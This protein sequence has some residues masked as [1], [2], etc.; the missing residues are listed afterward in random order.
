MSDNATN[1][2]RV[3]R[4][5]FED[6]LDALPGILVLKIDDKYYHFGRTLRTGESVY[7]EVKNQVH[8]LNWFEAEHLLVDIEMFF[9]ESFPR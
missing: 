1:E 7:N 8:Q 3:Y 9:V 2:V 4:V 5:K 6:D